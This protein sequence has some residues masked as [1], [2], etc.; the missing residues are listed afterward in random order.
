MTFYL[1]LFT[2]FF[3]LLTFIVSILILIKTNKK[4]DNLVVQTED[5]TNK[6]QIEEQLLEE[7]TST[8]LLQMFTVRNAVHKQTT[9]PH[10][11][12]IERAPRL[13]TNEITK[14]ESY[15][16]NDQLQLIQQFSNLFTHYLHQ[17]WLTQD[18]KIKT[19]FT[20]DV[21]K[22]TGDVGKMIAASEVLLIKL[23]RLMKEFQLISG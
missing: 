8:L 13:L 10:A 22:K 16:S 4:P 11:K 3:T 19:V 5:Q 20:G 21:D 18:G 2:S 14:L 7:V 15:F 17:Y 1:L 12:R 9:G 23:D 6:V